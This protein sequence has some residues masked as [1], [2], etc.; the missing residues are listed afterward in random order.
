MS[1]RPQERTAATP[2]AVDT[3]ERVAEIVEAIEAGHGLGG[4]RLGKRGTTGGAAVGARL[5]DAAEIGVPGHRTPAGHPYDPG[6]GGRTARCGL[7]VDLDAAIGG[8][9]A[10]EPTLLPEE[11]AEADRPT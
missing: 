1:E 4:R 11:T 2:R 8:H 10:E 6:M 7:G 9:Q 5:Q 3:D